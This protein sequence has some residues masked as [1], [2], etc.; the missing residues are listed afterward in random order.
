M[1]QKQWKALSAIAVVAM[2][3]ALFGL[4]YRFVGRTAH[5]ASPAAQVPR[6]L[7]AQKGMVWFELPE[8]SGRIDMVGFPAGTLKA[9]GSDEPALRAA[10]PAWKISRF[11][12]SRALLVPQSK[13]NP[14]TIGTKD[15]YVTLFLGDPKLGLV[16]QITGIRTGGLLA[17][18]QAR[19][20]KGIAV[21]G[22][23]AAWQLMEGL[24]G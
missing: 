6:S 21:A 19:L 23:A 13:A 8:P 14:L 4:G 24:A 3:S 17:Q 15:G 12:A 11:S 7:N 16:Y 1:R 5:T 18:D 20:K 22:P 10:L 2:L 9:V